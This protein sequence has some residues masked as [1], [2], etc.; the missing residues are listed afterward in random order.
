MNCHSGLRE[1]DLLDLWLANGSINWEGSWLI[2]QIF[3]MYITWPREGFSLPDLSLSCWRIFLNKWDW[4]DKSQR[5]WGSNVSRYAGT[6]KGDL[7]CCIG[8][9]LKRYQDMHHSLLSSLHIK[10]MK[11][12]EFGFQNFSL[13]TQAHCSQLIFFLGK[14]WGTKNQWEKTASTQ[15]FWKDDILNMC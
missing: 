10:R 9:N 4:G 5:L 15:T 14:R 8:S 13:W 1:G 7:L 11:V 12:R 6:E 2:F 3:L